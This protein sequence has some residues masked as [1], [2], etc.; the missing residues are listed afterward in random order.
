M[1]KLEISQKTLLWDFDFAI[2]WWIYYWAKLSWLDHSWKTL[3]L[4]YK[5]TSRV[6]KHRVS[7]TIGKQSGLTAS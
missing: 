7:F 6:F 1:I 4:Y 5:L 3:F 2:T